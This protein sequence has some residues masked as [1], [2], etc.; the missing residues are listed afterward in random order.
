M[1]PY[2]SVDFETKTRLKLVIG[3]KIY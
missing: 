2:F 1:G 3:F